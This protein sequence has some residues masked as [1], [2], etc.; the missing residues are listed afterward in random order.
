MLLLLGSFI[1]KRHLKEAF[2]PDAAKKSIAPPYTQTSGA[3]Q[4]HESVWERRFNRDKKGLKR[5][6]GLGFRPR[7]G[8]ADSIKLFV[9][10]AGVFGSEPENL[11][12]G[13]NPVIV[14][15]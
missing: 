5:Y 2:I 15:H 10:L 11:G 3:I 1:K 14:H 8:S 13:K 4:H 9:K 7:P 6:R 12:V